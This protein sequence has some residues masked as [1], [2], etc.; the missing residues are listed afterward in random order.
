MALTNTTKLEAVNTMLTSIGETPVNSITSAT[1]TDV[2]IAISILDSVS[3]ETQQ[4]GWF[5]NTDLDYKF[6]RNTNNQIELP[7]NVLRLDTTYLSK[8]Y[9]LVERN[10]KLYNRRENTFNLTEDVYVNVIWYLDFTE[11]PEVARRYITIRSSRIFQDRMLGSAT[12]HKFH[13]ADE[14]RAL[15]ELKEAEGDIAEHNIFDNYDT[16]RV[17]D[18]QHY[19]PNKNRT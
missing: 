13:E 18:R 17:I 15:L 16:Y 5:F 3:R 10:R 7:V 8:K 9:D 2:S 12:L 14:F 11:I 1:T 4:Q 6:T 19:Q